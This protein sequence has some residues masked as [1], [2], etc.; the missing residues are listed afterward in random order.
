MATTYLKPV[1]ASGGRSAAATISDSIDYGKNPDKTDEGR[2]VSAYGCDITSSA[3]QFML[4]K[5]EY[6]AQGGREQVPSRDVLLYH[7]RQS[8]KPGEITPEKALEVS[9]DLAKR[10]TKGNHAFVCS[11]HTDKGHVHCHIHFNAVALDAR[12]KFDDFSYS[13]MA[14]RRL[15]D[16]ICIENGL[17]II[18]KPKQRSANK[19]HQKEVWAQQKQE[20]KN[21][22]LPNRV[23]LRRDINAAID[24]TP[25]NFDE[26]LSI[27]KNDFGYEIKSRG[28]NITASHK[29]FDKSNIRLS[30]KLGENYSAEAIKR[31]ILDPELESKLKSEILRSKESSPSDL[32]SKSKPIITKDLQSS[33]ENI[34]LAQPQKDKAAINALIYLKENKIKSYES[35]TEKSSAANNNLNKTHSQIKTIDKR[36]DEIKDLNHHIENYLSTNET[37]IKYKEGGYKKSFE[38]KN[39]SQLLLHKAARDY[40]NKHGYGGKDGKLLPKPAELTTENKKLTAQKSQ[41]YN[42]YRKAQ[43]EQKEINNTKIICDRLISNEKTNLIP[44]QENNLIASQENNLN[45]SR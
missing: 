12:K 18:E 43:Q 27:L 13:R 33:I 6:H 30:E 29:N 34:I 28:K 9:H 17:S 25:K 41:L 7:M 1:K 8:F 10:F 40:F 44:T 23:A 21:A 22:K 39:I 31:R 2:L 26:F 16:H 15:S 37:Y 5:Q 32:P 38:E 45:T 3:D 20:A 24:K 14:L 35:L 19:Q 42:S 36:L 4:S 11:V